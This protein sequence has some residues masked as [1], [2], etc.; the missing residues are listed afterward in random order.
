MLVSRKGLLKRGTAMFSLGQGNV[1]I[2]SFFLI[3][4]GIL[5]KKEMPQ[6][7]D[8]TCPE[9][10]VKFRKEKIIMLTF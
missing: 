2:A 8:T 4:E 5:D 7:K 3:S 6:E 9:A 1:N 10:G